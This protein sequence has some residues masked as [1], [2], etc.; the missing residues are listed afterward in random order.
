[1]KVFFDLLVRLQQ[2]LDKIVDLGAGPDADQVR[3][4]APAGA[5]DRVALDTGHVVATVDR[6]AAGRV[7][8]RTDF[9][10]EPG[11]TPNVLAT[12][13]LEFSNTAYLS[14]F[15]TSNLNEI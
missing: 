5:G 6:L 15:L 14:M 2:R 3:P 9:G 1:M 7:T 4:D 12:T 8:V 13:T 11:A 10:D